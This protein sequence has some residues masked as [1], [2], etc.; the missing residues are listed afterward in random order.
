[1]KR[2]ILFTLALVLVV[3][4]LCAP[5]WA[6]QPKKDKSGGAPKDAT[7]AG[8]ISFADFTGKL[9]YKVTERFGIV[10]SFILPKGWELVEGGIDPKTGKVRDDMEIYSLISRAPV[11]KKGD[12]TDFIFEMDIVKRGLLD[13]LPG[14]T[15]ENERD[16][17]TQFWGFL[18]S[19]ISMNL[20][21]GMKC[22]TKTR[23][24]E[25]KPYGPPTR[26]PTMFVPIQYEVPPPPKSKGKNATLYTFTSVVGDKVWM[27]KF[28]VNKDQ[29]DAYDDLIAL[30]LRNSFGET[31]ADFDARMKR[32]KEQQQAQQNAPKGAK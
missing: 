31:Q 27:M 23:D 12:P 13:N 19:Q 6:A 30:M 2:V 3:P 25:A 24:I 9:D 29:L 26:E 8:A 21:S 28:L 11:A 10:I 18:N 4:V 32:I 15:P 17:A 22:V 16:S 20:K 1:M 14:N 5:A 7:G